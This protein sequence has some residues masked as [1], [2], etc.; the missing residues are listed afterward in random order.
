[1]PETMKYSEF[2]GIFYATHFGTDGLNA[3]Q[4]RKRATTAWTAYKKHMDVK[5]R[6]LLG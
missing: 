3:E 4:F 5:P 2:M 1:M 6:E